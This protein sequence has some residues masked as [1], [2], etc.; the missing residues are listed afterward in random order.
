MRIAVLSDTHGNLTAFEA[1]LAD[2]DARGVDQVIHLGDVAGKGPRG[3]ACCALTRD[4]CDVVVRGNWD[5]FLLRQPQDLPSNA[6]R[7]WRSELSESDLHWFAHLPFCHDFSLAGV[8]IRAYHASS[9]S[10][11]HRIYP[12]VEGEEW[13]DLFANT[14]ETGQGPVPDIVIYGDIH[15]AWE[16]TVGDRTMINCGSVGNPLDQPLPSYL[17]LDDDTGVLL[18]ELIRVPYDVEAE[19]AVARSVNMPQYDWWEQELRTAI[20]ARS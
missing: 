13:D 5:D 18:W 9:D 3:S 14:R 20:Y 1:V 15:Y 12:N 8:R 16:R 19:L 11:Y 17:L 6:S 2:I 10:V 4:R 7:W